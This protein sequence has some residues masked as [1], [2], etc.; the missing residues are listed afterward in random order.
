MAGRGQHWLVRS[1]SSVG[2]RPAWVPQPDRPW[3]QHRGPGKG[4]GSAAPGQGLK[5][6]ACDPAWAS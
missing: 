4:L 5:S 2:R 6:L 3:P 1:C